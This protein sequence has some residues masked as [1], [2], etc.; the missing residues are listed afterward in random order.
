M[1]P[2]SCH[3]TRAVWQTGAPALP[4]ALLVWM[5]AACTS[6][7]SLEG[8][9]PSQALSAAQAAETDLGRWVAPQAEEHPGR[10]GVHL[11]A[12]PHD[13]FAARMRL[14]AA[15]RHTLDI[16]YYIWR[17]D[18]TGMLLFD[19]LYRAA[20][21][22]VRVRLLLDDYNTS[23]MD[24]LLASL[25]A[26]HNIEIR[27]FNPF[28]VRKPRFWE[29]LT[30]LP[31]VNRRMHNKTFIAD[32]TVV[33][34]GGRNVADEYFGATD[35]LFTDLDVLAV[36]PVVGDVS[37]A[38]DQY[39]SS[40]SA[41]PIE[42]V[43][44]EDGAEM[45]FAAPDG[46]HAREYLAELEEHDPVAALRDREL[47]LCWSETHLVVDDPAKALREADGDEL[48]LA[49]LNDVVGI[50]ESRLDIISSY[51]IPTRVGVEELTDLTAQ[52]VQVRVLTNSMAATDV[53]LV[54]SGYAKWRDELL[55]GG[56]LLYEMKRGDEGR[57]SSNLTAGPY[58]SASS[59]LHAKAFAVDGEQL[60][61]GSFNAD[62]RSVHLNTELGLVISCPELA[63]KIHD[64]FPEGVMRHA[65]QVRLGSD[66]DLY[67]LEMDGETLI[68]HDREPNT[69]LWQR[70]SVPIFS[71]L[72][73]DGFL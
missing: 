61:V 29:I 55:E 15:A 22:G 2:L 43:L 48:F 6:L 28:M 35:T 4:I 31:R 72:P 16:Q 30:D 27:L 3:P 41:Y 12:D 38:F 39:W 65:Y 17:A 26:H 42:R 44:G 21:R 47:A 67:W 1:L 64:A 5:L 13:A 50:P 52:G 51:F 46:E 14:A 34:L 59:T 56:V 53:A 45:E 9:A 7:P 36:G 19:A 66:G 71:I 37:A 33:V 69:T 54:H 68:R 32:N 11:L 40:Q 60:V 10:S 62:P 63:D 70:L 20:D 49:Q 23:G 25:N 24:S 18:T 57:S 58:G 8:R 73:I